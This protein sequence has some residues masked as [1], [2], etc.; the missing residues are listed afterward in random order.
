MPVIDT[1]RLDD[2]GKIVEHWNVLLR[3]ASS[4]TNNNSMC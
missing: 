2:Q 3:V 4:A 1:R